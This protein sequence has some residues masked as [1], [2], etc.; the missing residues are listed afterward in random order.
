MRN[1]SIESS[2]NEIDIAMGD[3][4]L[5]EMRIADTRTILKNSTTPLWDKDRI[6]QVD[7]LTTEDI[8]N[9]Y[10]IS[11]DKKNIDITYPILGYK[12]NNI[13]EVFYGTGNRIGQWKFEVPSKTNFE[14]NERVQIIRGN[15]RSYY[16]IIKQVFDNNLY[17]VFVSDLK[18]FITCSSSDL[19]SPTLEGSG[20][21]FKAKQIITSY[22]VA[23][24]SQMR[25]ESRYLMDKFILRCADGQIWHPYTSNLINGQ[26]FHIFTVFEIPNINKY[27]NDDQ[28]IKGIGYVYGIAFKVNVWAYLFDEPTPEGFIEQIEMNLKIN[29]ESKFN[30]ITIN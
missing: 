3:I 30:K 2:L 22:D 8:F 20:K 9:G 16:G 27:P 6:V 23:I 25:K 15:Y 18:I 5:K 28:K 17:Q 24:L 13:D 14:V 4:L 19:R 21:T 7:D 1:N 29:N 12:A 11:N 26:E 10:L